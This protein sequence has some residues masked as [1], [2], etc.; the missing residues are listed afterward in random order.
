MVNAPNSQLMK[1]VSFVIIIFFFTSFVMMAQK[2]SD[3]ALKEANNPLAD[4][5]AVNF[6]NYYKPRFSEAPAQSYENTFWV[7]YAQPFAKG[8]LLMRASVPLTTK[9]FGSDSMGIPT[10]NS[11]LGD[12]NIFVS[13]NFISKADKTIGV[14]PLLVAPTASESG[15]GDSKWQAGLAFVVYIAKS[16]SF[17]FG[18]LVTW[19]ASFSGDTDKPNTN[20]MAIQPF[21]FWQLGKG[22]YLR[23]ASIWIF[24]IENGNYFVPFSLGIGKVVKVNNTVFNLFIEP[25]YSILHKGT[26]PQFQIYTGINMQF[27]KNKN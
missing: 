7:R 11:G 19:Q 20:T 12:A 25:Q 1:K 24:D 27:M 14:G 23:T 4:I 2:I 6:Q 18:G 3:D 15:L 16:S 9:S 10:S 13:Y 17:Q 5:I 22:T 8:R 26:M 21:L